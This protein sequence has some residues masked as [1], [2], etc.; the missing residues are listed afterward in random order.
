M[1]AFLF[2]FGLA[3][4]V[5]TYIGYAVV[6]TLLARLKGKKAAVG[7]KAEDMPTVTLVVPAYNEE[8]FIKT[9]IENSLR[10]EYPD[11]KLNILFVADGSTDRTVEIIEN[12]PQVNLLYDNRRGG[13]AAAINHALAH[14]GTDIVV[15]NDANTML[16]PDTIIKLVQPFAAADVAASSGEKRILVRQ[17]DGTQAQG[18]GLYWKYESY[19]KRKDAETHS[20]M[21]AAG[22]LIAFRTN[23]I[24][25]LDENT[26]LD[27]FMMTFKLIEKGFRVAYVPQ[28]KATETASATVNDELGRKVR[29][30]AGGWQAMARLTGLL[31]FWKTP[32]VSFMYVSHR[33]LRWSISAFALPVVFI[34][35]MLLIPQGSPYTWLAIAQLGFYMLAFIGFL[36]QNKPKQHKLFYVPFYFTLMNYAVWAG[37]FRYLKGNQSAVW[38]R[39]ARAA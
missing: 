9:K 12:Y 14:V 21:G 8:G 6:I 29:I 19:L 3:L 35:N 26:I 5:Y 24:E 34:F 32:L 2:W 10:L 20:V 4:I 23:T 22:E 18:E 30:A 7:F 13:K 28:A 36:L 16:E 25:K 15:F 31:K 1:I 33:V 39:V 17:E 38:A 11:N 37:F 27:D